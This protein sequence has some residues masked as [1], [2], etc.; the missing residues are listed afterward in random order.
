MGT[1]HERHSRVGETTYNYVNPA[2]V[3][4]RPIL[5][6]ADR[7]ARAAVVEAHGMSEYAARIRRGETA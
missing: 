3:A 2:A 1:S 7:E 6:A 4:V 5:T